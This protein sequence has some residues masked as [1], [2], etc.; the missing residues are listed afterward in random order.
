M[1]EPQTAYVYAFSS[2]ILWG[3]W[4]ILAK[5]S[6]DY[7]DETTVLLVTY[8]VGI[9][10]IIAIRPDAVFGINGGRGLL[11]AVG[12]GVAMGIGAVFYYRSVALGNLSI[13][14]AIPAL[15]FVVTTVYGVTVLDEQVTATQLFGVVLAIAAV[16]LMTR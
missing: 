11:L 14:P 5:H 9:G 4:G 13:I 7:M 3:I 8:I 6:M 15:Y 16:V 12:T 1:F 2:M 10:V